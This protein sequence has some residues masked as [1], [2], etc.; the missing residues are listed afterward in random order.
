MIHY[1]CCWNIAAIELYP[2]PVQIYCV[3]CS[4]HALDKKFLLLG[5]GWALTLSIFAVRQ[6]HR[7]RPYSQSVDLFT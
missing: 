3:Q 4:S 7:Q 6:P 2:Y 1:M 5:Q